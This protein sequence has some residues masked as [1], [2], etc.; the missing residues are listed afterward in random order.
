MEYG[1]TGV[2]GYWSIG[3][4]EGLLFRFFLS[5]TP[6]LHHSITPI[7]FYSTAPLLQ[8]SNFVEEDRP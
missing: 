2:L 7:F 8:Y 3:V 1:R 6:L 4:L 5:I